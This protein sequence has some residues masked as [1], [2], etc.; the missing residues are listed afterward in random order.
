MILE[1]KR[2]SDYAKKLFWHRDKLNFLIL[3]V[4]SKCNLTCGTCFFHKNL[5]KTHDLNFGE[6]AKIANSAGSFSIL[7]LAGGEPFLSPDLEKICAVFVEKCQIDT[8]FIPTNGTLTE[9]ILDKTEKI[10]KRFPQLSVS[11]NPSLD[12]MECYHDQNRGA[13]GTFSKCV[14]TIEKLSALKKEYSNLQ[15]IVNSVI[16]KD[17]QQ[18]I[19]ELMEFLKKYAIDFQ[20]FEL[21][22]GDYRDQTLNLPEFSEVRKMHEAILENRYWYLQKK[23]KT[24]KKDWLFKLEE[25]AV[26]G[27]L[28]YA[29]TFKELALAGEK[30]PC[31]C[32]A[33]KSI[34][35]INPDGGFSVCEMKPSLANLRQYDYDMAKF[36]K[37]KRI[38]V[39]N[40]DCTHICFIHSAIAARPISVLKIWLNY[41]KARKIIKK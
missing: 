6:Y 4:T 35:V 34:A 5:N 26:M 41:R 39:K 12:G 23:K 17:N 36:I 22:R 3:Y 32:M 7:A 15:V 25:V 30:W 20:A 29:Q 38:V 21:L 14:E 33:G 19:L 9:V 8:L 1:I 24:L 10:L 27:T 40:C 2:Y 18:E 13:A 37:D 28:K 11:V 31:Q 16:N